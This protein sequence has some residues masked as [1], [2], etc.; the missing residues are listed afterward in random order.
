VIDKRKVISEIQNYLACELSALPVQ[1]PEALARAAEIRDLL[2]MYKFLPV[3][4]YGADDVICAGGLI[5]VE[6]NRTRAYCLLVPKGGGLVTSVE[7]KA[8]Q[9]VTQES[10]LGGALLGKRLGDEVEVTVGSGVRKYRV[11]AIS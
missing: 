9:V 8:V 10:P 3:R 1:K 2:L 4:E 11:V 5:E 6:V 7:G